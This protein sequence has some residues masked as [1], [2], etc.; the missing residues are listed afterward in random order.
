[1]RNYGVI[2]L[3]LVL[4]IH[5]YGT[6]SIVN[7]IQKARQ[8][9]TFYKYSNNP[10]TNEYFLMFLDFYNIQFENS[11]IK[12]GYIKHRNYKIAVYNFIP[13]H[14][15]ET[16]YLVHGY[17]DHVGIQKNLIEHLLQN[18]YEVVTFDLPGHGLSGGKIADID[19]FDTYTE[20]LNLIIK[21]TSSVNNKPYHL[22]GH[23]TGAATILNGLLENNIEGISKIILVSPLIH[24]N[25]W[26]SSIIGNSIAGIFTSEISRKFRNNSSNVEYLDFVKN[27]DVLQYKKFPLNWF[28][29]LVEWNKKIDNLSPSSQ[30]LLVI[31]GTRDSTVDWRYNLDF[32][33]KKFPNSDIIKIDNAEHQLYNE[34]SVIRKKVFSEITK[35]LKKE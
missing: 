21:T 9:L 6:E 13:D 23:S 29:A 3:L 16:I 30:K 2:I 35:Y 22:I 4:S 14:P 17:Y 24:S 5:L 28:N 19:S 27:K 11:K 18:N 15:I 20:I 25:Y 31:Q 26:N 32:I 7:T 34:S 8:N 33:V 10:E 1:M 12:S